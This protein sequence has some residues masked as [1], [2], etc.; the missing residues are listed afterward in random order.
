M[1]WK[2]GLNTRCSFEIPYSRRSPNKARFRAVSTQRPS[3]VT[4]PIQYSNFGSESRWMNRA[5]HARMT[6]ANGSNDPRSGDRG[7]EFI[8]PARWNCDLSVLVDLATVPRST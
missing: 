8:G 2:P 4:Y 7:D 6:K 1:A 3:S 5:M